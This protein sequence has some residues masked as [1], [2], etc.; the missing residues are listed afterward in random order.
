MALKVGRAVHGGLIGGMAGAWE[1]LGFCGALDMAVGGLDGG[2]LLGLEVRDLASWLK[3][4]EAQGNS[5]AG[6][7][8]GLDRSSTTFFG[9]AA[10]FGGFDKVPYLST[11]TPPSRWPEGAGSVSSAL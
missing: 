1:I 10:S 5:G 2:F 3:G 11:G 4:E 8:S 6:S 9:A 7:G